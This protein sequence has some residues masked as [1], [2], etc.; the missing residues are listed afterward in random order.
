MVTSWGVA[1]TGSPRAAGSDARRAGFFTGSGGCSS[2]LRLPQCLQRRPLVPIAAV[3]A[4]PVPAG[5]LGRAMGTRDDEYDYLFKGEA[6]VPAPASRPVLGAVGWVAGWSVRSLGPARS[7]SSSSRPGCPRSG[8]PGSARARASRRGL[9]W[10]GLPARSAGPA[11]SEQERER[12]RAA[13]PP[14][15]PARFALSPPA[16]LGASCCGAAEAPAS[17]GRHAGRPACMHAGRQ[18]AGK[19]RRGPHPNTAGVGLARA[20][21]LQSWGASPVKGGRVGSRPAPSH[22]AKLIT[23]T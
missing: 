13:P 11:S 20:V 21:A 1:S 7:P 3:A 22:R 10:A 2:A 9:G 17:P 15:T 6:G 14:P 16:C 12:P 18:R 19:G 4:A 23:L 8:P 5:L